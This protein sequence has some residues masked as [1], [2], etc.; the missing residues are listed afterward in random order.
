MST[1]GSIVLALDTSTPAVTAAVV[2]VSPDTITTL[3]DVVQV[4]PRRHG[5]L[6]SPAISQVLRTVDCSP[7]D[8]SAIVVGVG[9]G[10]FTGLRIGL[11]TAAALGDALSIPTYGVCSLDGI[12]QAVSDDDHLLVATDAKRRELYWAAYDGQRQ[13]IVGP[14]VDTPA[15]LAE[16]IPELGITTMAGDGAAL[17]ADILALPLTGPRFPEPL[18]LV[19]A[20]QERIVSGAPSDILTPMYLRR[21]DV[22]EPKQSP[23]PVTQAQNQ[24]P[25]LNEDASDRE[26]IVGKR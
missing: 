21:P 9:P 12:A 17:A 25:A 2:S 13:R 22:T 1:S 18:A 11:V 26:Q 5:E 16:Q 10:P 24:F 14:N 6:L 23:A 19:A 7:A 3:A 8:L 20:A 15:A 4:D